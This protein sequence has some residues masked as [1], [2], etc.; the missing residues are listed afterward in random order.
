VLIL[1]T[2]TIY[3][4]AICRVLL[5]H[6]I[7]VRSINPETEPIAAVLEAVASM[8]PSLILLGAWLDGDVI[9]QLVQELRGTCQIIIV[10]SDERGELLSSFRSLSTETSAWLTLNNTHDLEQFLTHILR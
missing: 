5:S 8:A 2:G 1:D 6:D 3:F 4:T 7:P 10:T 9:S